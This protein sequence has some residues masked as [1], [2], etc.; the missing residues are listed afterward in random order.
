MFWEVIKPSVPVLN[1]WYSLLKNR[2]QITLLHISM[3][4]QQKQCVLHSFKI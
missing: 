3:H 2:I 1:A 4:T